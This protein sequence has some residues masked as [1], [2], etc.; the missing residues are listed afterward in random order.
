[1]SFLAYFKTRSKKMEFSLTKIH[2]ALIGISWRK[3]KNYEEFIEINN[4]LGNIF[5]EEPELRSATIQPPNIPFMLEMAG[6]PLIIA[7]D[8]DTMCEFTAAKE[9]ADFFSGIKSQENLNFFIEKSHALLKHYNMVKRLG[10][11]ASYTVEVSNEPKWF[12]ESIFSTNVDNFS[13]VSIR[14]NTKKMFKQLFESNKIIQIQEFPIFNNVEKSCNAK[15]I[16]LQIDINTPQGYELV[17]KQA[18]DFFNQKIKTISLIAGE[19][20]L[21]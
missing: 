14:Y 4:S 2:L 16:T 7:K 21:K 5:S 3:L 11:I 19:S 10:I 15:R 12:S 8:Q 13:E 1:M 18:N 6:V 9:R 17:S 20:I